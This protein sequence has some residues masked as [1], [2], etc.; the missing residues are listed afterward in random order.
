MRLLEAVR[1]TRS[2]ARQRSVWEQYTARHGKLTLEGVAGFLGAWATGHKTADLAGRAAALR[3]EGSAAGHTLTDRQWG[4]I[5]AVVRALRVTYPVSVK[6]A[7][8]LTAAGYDRLWRHLR[9]LQAPVGADVRSFMG[10]VEL[11][12]M[13]IMRVTALAGGN[14]RVCD[15]RLETERGRCVVF[16]TRPLSKTNKVEVETR[17]TPATDGSPGGR[18]AR[19]LAELREESRLARGEEGA[20]LVRGTGDVFARAGDHWTSAAVTAVLRRHLRAAGVEDPAMYSTKSLKAGAVTDAVDCGEPRLEIRRRAGW[21]GDAERH[22]DG[23]A[24]LVEE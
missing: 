11:A 14:V 1:T 17:P 24:R 9:P 19:L 4:E 12:R 8:P 2:A 5:K 22:Y 13:F 20:L 21:A 10:L 16:L 7:R 15:L 3:R 6:K 18:V 23:R